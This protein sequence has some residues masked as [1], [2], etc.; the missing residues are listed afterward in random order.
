MN[1][2]VEFKP[3]F[4]LR[5]FFFPSHFLFWVLILLFGAIVSRSIIFTILFGSSSAMLVRHFMNA[6]KT[7]ITI[8]NDI[9]SLHE[10]SFLG[11]TVTRSLSLKEVHK[12]QLVK[13][14]SRYDPVDKYLLQFKI[15]VNEDEPLLYKEK[16]ETISL[17]LWDDATIQ[18]LI[19]HIKNHYPTIDWVSESDHFLWKKYA[20]KA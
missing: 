15:P 9:L 17:E 3:K 16:G 5:K 10:V 2:I 11:K 14:F 8:R 13:T 4:S 7:S 20:I 6:R 1:D 19:S 18:Q 12:A